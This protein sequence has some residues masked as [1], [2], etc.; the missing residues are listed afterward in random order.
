MTI[1]DAKKG[2]SGTDG[3]VAIGNATLSREQAFAHGTNLILIKE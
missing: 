3:S 2:K 1:V